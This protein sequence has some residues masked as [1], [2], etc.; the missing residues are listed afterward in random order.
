MEGCSADR[1]DG[2]SAGVEE[3]GPID[4]E[5]CSGDGAGDRLGLIPE[6]FGTS[7][8]VLAVR[9]G[10]ERLAR[11]WLVAGELRPFAFARPAARVAAAA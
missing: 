11:P 6:A 10:V 8:T 4:A 9:A 3:D 2:R 1:E 7:S 5:G